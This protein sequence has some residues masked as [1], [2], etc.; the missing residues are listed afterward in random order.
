MTRPPPRLKWHMLRRRK[1]DPGHFRANL[2][3]AL[4]VGAACEVDLHF[5][6]EIGRAHV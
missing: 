6:A 2:E 5:T 3:Q 4:R 1:S